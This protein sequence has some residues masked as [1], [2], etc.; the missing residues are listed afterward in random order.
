[1]AK[2]RKAVG[3]GVMVDPA[4]RAGRLEA[5]VQQVAPR[6]CAHYAT[7]GCWP[8]GEDGA[9]PGPPYVIRTMADGGRK[10]ELRDD[11]GG[12]QVGIGRTVEEALTALEAKLAR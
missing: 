6:A 11:D 3:G 8:E 9:R 7:A 1:M 12:T 10:I 4:S 5:L 2:T